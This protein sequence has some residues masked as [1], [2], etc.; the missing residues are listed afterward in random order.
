MRNKDKD[1][2]APETEPVETGKAPD[3]TAEKAVNEAAATDEAPA[4]E[5]SEK[6]PEA[7]G[8]TAGAEGETPEDESGGAD[9]E[10]AEA[11]EPEEKKED[12]DLK[13]Q[14]L[15]LAADFQNFRKRTEKEKG[16]I[17]ARANEALMTD[18]LPVLDDFERALAVK[19]EA[20]KGVQDG[21][22][23]IVDKYV[24]A[25]KKHGLFEIEALGADFDPNFHHAVQTCPAE[26][27]NE[28][29]VAVVLQKGY[30]LK[31]K[32]IRPAMV[33]VAE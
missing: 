7:N 24:A 12:E 4:A 16:D 28:G 31:G 8:E 3:E 2:K 1:R 10:A 17:Y 27:G 13:T 15:R 20:A 11:P 29:K 23:M 25:L 30:M 9:P 6:A 26:N 19:D 33:I 21:V 5:Q 22:R 32:V 18:L 14:Y